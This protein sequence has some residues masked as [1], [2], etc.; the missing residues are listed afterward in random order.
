VPTV[1]GKPLAA[2]ASC[3]TAMA[4]K[5]RRGKTCIVS[6]SHRALQ[7]SYAGNLRQGELS[8]QYP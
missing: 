7:E 6:R 8:R 1:T 3:S 4:G 2:R 5:D